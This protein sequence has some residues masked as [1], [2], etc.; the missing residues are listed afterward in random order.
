MQHG[1]AGENQM[2]WDD[3]RMFLA[4]AEQGSYRRAAL[5]TNIGYSTLSR[6]IESL[7]HSLGA[8]LFLRQSTGLSLTPAGLELLNTA[9]PMRKEFDC[10]RSRLLAQEKVPSGTIRFTVPSLMVNYVLMDAI[11]EFLKLWPDIGLD[12]DSSL[13]LLDLGAREADLAIRMTNHPGDDLMGR[14]VGG[15]YEAVYASPVYLNEFLAAEANEHRWIYPG[16]NYQFEAELSPMYQATPTISITLPDLESQMLAAER[17]LG[18]AT[19]PCVMG[20]DHDS[21]VRISE[22]YKRCDIWLLAHPDTRGNRRMQIFRDFL[23]GVFEGQRQ[24]LSGQPA[25]KAAAS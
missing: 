3:V 6:R 9:S 10:L 1:V 4:V 16:G 12:I 14:K 8:R 22:P 15:F 5:K 19:L 21:L 25:K 17:N 7:E 13:S 23:V 18:I 2:N 11:Q 20:D 24:V